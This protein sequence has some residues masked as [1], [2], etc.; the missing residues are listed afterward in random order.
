MFFGTDNT[1]RNIPHIQPERWNFLQNIVNP[2][3]HYYEFEYL[4]VPCQS[5]TTIL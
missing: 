5:L 2:A 4:Y 1:T 3:E